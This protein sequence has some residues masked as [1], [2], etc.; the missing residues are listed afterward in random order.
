MYFKQ[1][2]FSKRHCFSAHSQLQNFISKSRINWHYHMLKSWNSCARD[3]VLRDKILLRIVLEKDNNINT[4]KNYQVPL[5]SLRMMK[6]NAYPFGT[7]HTSGQY[8]MRYGRPADLLLCFQALQIKYCV[9][10]SNRYFAVLHTSWNMHFS[11]LSYQKV[12]YYI[13]VHTCI[14]WRQK[15]IFHEHHF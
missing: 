4:H 13:H 7:I 2:I 15:N 12:L 10:M 14:D 6:C 9:Y 3:Y 11:L 5:F 8:L 1:K